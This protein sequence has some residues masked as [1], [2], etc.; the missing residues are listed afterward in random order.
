MSILGRV[1]TAFFNYHQFNEMTQM[2]DETAL[3]RI[4]TALDLAFEKALHY[5]DKR[6]E[7]DNDYGL[8]A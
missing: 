5:H 7:S 6:Y 4:T 2:P 3:A 8:P 1:H